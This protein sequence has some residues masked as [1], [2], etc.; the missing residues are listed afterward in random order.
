VQLS[1]TIL[2]QKKQTHLCIYYV[3]TLHH[4][5]AVTTSSAYHGYPWERKEFGHQEDK[6]GMFVRWTVYLCYTCN[7][8]VIYLSWARYNQFRVQS[9]L[10]TDSRSLF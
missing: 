3:C 10:H 1:K 7:T 9:I 5:I 8:S 4:P 2:R 6:N